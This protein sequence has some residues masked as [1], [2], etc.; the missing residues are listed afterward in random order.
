M[1]DIYQLSAEVR[2]QLGKGANRR[3]RRLANQIPAVV[4][5]IG[6]QPLSIVLNGH[7]FN[8]ALKNEGFFSHI[9][10]LSIGGAAEK[11]VLK[12]LHRHPSKPQILHADF[13]RV[14]ATEKLQMT[15]PLHFVNEDIAP[16]VK[17]ENGQVARL[18]NDV[19]IRCL[20]GDLP[21][22]IEVDLSNLHINESIHLSQLKLPKN[23]EVIALMHED[24]RAVANIHAIHIIEEPETVEAAPAEVPTL[25]ETEEGESENK[26]E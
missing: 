20:P 9:L 4:Y 5:G 6:K 16:G 8:N 12:D 2:N 22:F 14:S 25:D 24:D 17:L 10:T 15:V 13:L 21:E 19:E 26:G 7:Q 1:S 23:V 3:M 18:M 11:V